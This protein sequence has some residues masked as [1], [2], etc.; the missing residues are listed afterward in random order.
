MDQ[1]FLSDDGNYTKVNMRTITKY[2]SNEDLNSIGLQLFKIIY[3]SSLRPTLQEIDN[4]EFL[5]AEHPLRH[6]TVSGAYTIALESLKKISHIIFNKV[7]DELED[8]EIQY[9]INQELI[10]EFNYLELLHNGYDYV[11]L[12]VSCK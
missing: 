5:R 9:I 4:D 6:V 7:V 1:Y 8:Q 12:R 2:I 3:K 10:K 11:I